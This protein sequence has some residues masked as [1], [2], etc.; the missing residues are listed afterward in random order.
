M[1]LVP[2]LHKS[3]TPTL[4]L[5]TAIRRPCI[6]HLWCGVWLCRLWRFLKIS[7]QEIPLTFCWRHLEHVQWVFTRQLHPLLGKDTFFTPKRTSNSDTK[8]NVHQKFCEARNS[9]CAQTVSF[10]YSSEHS[11]A[12]FVSC[13]LRRTSFSHH[14]FSKILR[15]A[16][17]TLSCRISPLQ[18]K[19]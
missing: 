2:G 10:G 5:Y 17:Q 9:A 8:I 18:R 4:I 12:Q 16:L 3:T 13:L 6:L 14:K 19:F 15:N 7:G 1:N 11:P